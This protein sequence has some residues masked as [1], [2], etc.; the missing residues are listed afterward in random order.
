[1]VRTAADSAPTQ[2]KTSSPSNGPAR[3]RR[4][5]AGCSRPVACRRGAASARRRRPVPAAAAPPRRRPPRCSATPRVA[6]GG[7]AEDPADRRQG[8]LVAGEQQLA[9]RPLA[10]RAAAGHAQQRAGR[11]RRGPGGGRTVAVQ[12]EVD[13]HLA[14]GRVLPAGGVAA[15]AHP[16]GAVGPDDPPVL[17]DPWPPRIGVAH[18]RDQQVDGRVRR[19]RRRPAV[20]VRTTRRTDGVTSA[21]ATTVSTSIGRRPS[22]RG[23]AAGSRPRS[24]EGRPGRPRGME[25]TGTAIAGREQISHWVVVVPRSTSV[26]AIRAPVAMNAT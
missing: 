19:P 8:G 4:R 20:P 26:H 12:H 18:P 11:G 1:M 24:V 16:V 17:G 9:G 25:S 14:G 3:R 21:T 13:L 15:Q 6:G 22:S 7:G 2:A 5:R 23:V 10:E